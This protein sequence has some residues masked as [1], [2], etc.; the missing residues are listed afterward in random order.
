MC[1]ANFTIRRLADAPPDIDTLPVADRADC[2]LLY[3]PYCGLFA[4]DPLTI[5]TNAWA[6]LQLTWT[7]MLLFVHLTQI[8]RSITTYET[9]KG[10]D[11]VG[12]ITTAI[13]I[14]SL[15]ADGA[16]VNGP[17]PVPK[18]DGAGYAH[19]HKRKDGCLSQ[20]YKLLGLDTFYTVAFQGYKGSQDKEASRRTK[21]SNPFSRGLFR[22]CQDFWMDGPIFGRKTSGKA[23]LGGEVVDYTTMY[24]APKGMR[25]RGGYE[26]VP[27]AEQ[28]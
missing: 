19:N 24:D 9:M 18:D 10:R 22:N 27:S 15:S 8:A 2:S 11:H 1:P 3:D 21:Q 14:G 7:F 6:S 25:Y 20:W 4:R 13:V 28:G 26:S 16:Q 23:M 5:I 17:D 12:P